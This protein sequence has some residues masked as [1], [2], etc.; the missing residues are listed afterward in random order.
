MAIIGTALAVGAVVYALSLRT[1][2]EQALPV[3]P[4]DEGAG[5]ISDPRARPRR[6]G[7]PRTTAGDDL[8]FS[9]QGEA[10]APDGLVYLPVLAGGGPR[11]RDRVAGVIGLIAIVVLAAAIVAVG[12]YQAGHMAN[13]MIE[14][15]LGR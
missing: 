11:W 10:P 12:I 15:F 6:R 4:V 13:G 5:P 2:A 3:H 1:G 9:S 14:E 8:G 7:R